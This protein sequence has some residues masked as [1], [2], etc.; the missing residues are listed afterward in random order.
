MTS[1]LLTSKQTCYLSPASKMSEQTSLPH[2]PSA[3]I[4]GAPLSVGGKLFDNA[5]QV[6]FSFKPV[7][8][9]KQALCALHPYAH[10]P[11]RS[12]PAYHYC[13]HNNSADLH[14]CLVSDLSYI[15]YVLVT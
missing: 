12:V 5:Q 6:A 4:A 14:Q 7:S 2:D 10:D 1:S 3:K 15:S 8:Q 9:I 13:T 11:G